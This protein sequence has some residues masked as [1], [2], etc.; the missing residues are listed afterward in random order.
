[1]ASTDNASV[2]AYADVYVAPLG[3][4]IPQGG[5]PFDESWEQVGLL[6]GEEGFTETLEAETEDL[7]AWGGILVASTHNNFKVT[8]KFLPFEDN[9]A[10]YDIMYPGHDVEFGEGGRFEGNINVPDLQAKFM[11]AFETRTGDVIKRTVSANY[12][13][14]AERG[15]STENATE[16][17]KR[18]ITVAIYPTDPENDK[19]TLFY[20]YK[21][22]ARPDDGDE[23]EN[24]GGEGRPEVF[25]GR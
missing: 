22:P 23:D 16:I 11:I 15:E 1:M 18:E 20:T 12:A 2:W 21:G 9:K 7:Y 4:T 3:S 5:R 8:R 17:A 14:V 25:G 6:D 24:E 13:Q 10:V 19:A